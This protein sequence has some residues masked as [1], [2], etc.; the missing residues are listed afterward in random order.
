MKKDVKQTMLKNIDKK[1]E[2][3]PDIEY[4]NQKLQSALGTKV[5]LD[6]KNN[7]GKI[8][9]EYYSSDERERIIELLT[10]LK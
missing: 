3:D 4:I 5:T 2:I 10:G 7:K 1:K 8:V 9:I 6:D